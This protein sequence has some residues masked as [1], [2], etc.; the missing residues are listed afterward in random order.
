MAIGE[1]CGQFVQE[2]TSTA[3]QVFTG[4]YSIAESSRRLRDT[5]GWIEIR[6]AT[7][8][9]MSITLFDS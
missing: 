2:P 1:V 7:D 6:L 9:R 4:E 3:T 8:D 5:E